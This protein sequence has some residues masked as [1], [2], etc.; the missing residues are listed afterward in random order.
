MMPAL[1]AIVLAAGAS[2]RLGRAKQLIE[3]DGEPALRRVVR[4]ALA[5]EPLDCI[6]VLG[7]DAARI[8]QALGNLRVHS[9]VADD[10]GNG[11]AASLRA[12]IGALDARCDGALIVLTDQPALNEAH[13]KALC[14]AWRVQPA[15]AVASAYA[16]LVGVP[17]VL[18][19][20][21]FADI[22]RLQGDVGARDLLR[23]RR[24]QVIAIS[25]AELEKDID[26]P[27]DVRNR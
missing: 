25:A 11:M 3:I 15:F 4:Y 7:H 14:D 9:V 18:P 20:A 21:W 8:E 17:A 26:T 5:T 6:V 24:E 2:K 1:G 27:E 22:A 10:F 16:N 19:R 13:L 12:G 23:A